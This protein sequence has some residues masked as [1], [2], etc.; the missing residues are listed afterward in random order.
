M[1][2]ESVGRGLFTPERRGGA[3]GEQEGSAFSKFEKE[4]RWRNGTRNDEI[5]ANFEKTFKE[6]RFFFMRDGNYR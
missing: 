5:L 3:A 6:S 1:A 2:A 4:G